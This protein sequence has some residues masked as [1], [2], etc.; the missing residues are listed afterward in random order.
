MINVTHAPRDR[1]RIEEVCEQSRNVAQLVGLK[2][3]NGFVLFL[4]DGFKALH[5]LLLQQ[6]EPLPR[7][8][9]GEINKR[10]REGNTDRRL[11]GGKK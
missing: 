9:R 1:V 11:A 3:V 8:I 7:F 2:S 10:E 6:T 5:V 4:E